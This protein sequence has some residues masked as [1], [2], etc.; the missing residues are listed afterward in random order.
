MEYHVERMDLERQ[1]T[2]VIRAHVAHDGIADFLGGAF[3][4]V[5]GTLGVQGLAP[6]GPP[7]AR[8][9]LTE[10]GFDIEAGFPASAPVTPSGRVEASELPGGTAVVVLHRGSY[11][12]VAAAYGAAEQWLAANQWT[13]TGAPWE[14]YLD[15]PEV[16]EPRTVVHW[17]CRPS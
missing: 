8:Y 12:D 17:P 4:E 5:I 2:A 6:A 13:A 7:Y 14:A 11:A 1:P 16:A 9:A 15:G 10:D 3:E